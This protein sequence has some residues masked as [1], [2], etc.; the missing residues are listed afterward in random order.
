MCR[1]RWSTSRP[2]R[3]RRGR[4]PG[5]AAGF[6]ARS[7]GLRSPASAPDLDGAT[8]IVRTHL[9]LGLGSGVLVCVPVPGGR[10]PP[11]RRRA[12]RRDP[13]RRRRRGRGHRR[14]GVDAVAAGP[15]SPRSRPGPPSGPTR[16]SSST[17]PGSRASSPSASPPSSPAANPDRSWR[18]A[19]SIV[20]DGCL[21]AV[22][23]PLPSNEASGGRLAVLPSDPLRG[24][25]CPPR[26]AS[27][28]RRRHR[29]A[30]RPAHLQGQAH[31][32]RRPRARR[33][34]RRAG[35]VLRPARAQRR[36]QDDAHQDPDDPAPA[37][38]G[39]R[40]DL[41]LRRQQG[42]EAHPPDHEH[43]R[44]RRAVGLRDPDRPRAALDV[45]PVLRP[46]A[47]GRLAPG[48]RAHRRRRHGRRARAAGQHPD[49]PA[50]A[51]R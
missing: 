50:S 10:G 3:R 30:W 16:R 51:R 22:R 34:G 20:F 1:R 48:R 2:W 11:R 17:T 47:Q 14:T 44:R 49:A 31:A 4:R 35:R 32:R 24:V 21:P 43:G 46:A 9:G 41:R 33:S 13:G 19:P 40:P 25:P 26:R 36:G 23:S 29:G 5:R 7:S 12:G 28:C 45:Q 8:A 42:R 15:R 27:S 6:F 37:E 18:L 38:R 39:H